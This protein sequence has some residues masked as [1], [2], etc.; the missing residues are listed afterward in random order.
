MYYHHLHLHHQQQHQHRQAEVASV[1]EPDYQLLPPVVMEEEEEDEEEGRGRE[2]EFKVAHQY[3]TLVKQYQRNEVSAVLPGQPPESAIVIK[4]V[5]EIGAFTHT[6]THTY[7][8]THTPH[9]CPPQ[10]LIRTMSHNLP[11]K[12]AQLLV[13]KKAILERMAKLKRPVPPV[14]GGEGEG[15]GGPKVSE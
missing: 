3:R 6:H 10:H 5:G 7:T 4:M 13:Q 1:D 14:G 11:D 15:G 12:G 8:H 2:P 9:T